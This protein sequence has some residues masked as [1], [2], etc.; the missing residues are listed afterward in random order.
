MAGIAGRAARRERIGLRGSRPASNSLT[1]L[2]AFP[3][4]LTATPASSLKS[5]KE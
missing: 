4:F 2:R 3:D 5:K 1:S